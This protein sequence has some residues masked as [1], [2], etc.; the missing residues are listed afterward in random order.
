MSDYMDRIRHCA[1]GNSSFP[2]VSLSR[3]EAS[4]LFIRI[5]DLGESGQFR[6]ARLA[7]CIADFW[8]EEY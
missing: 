2:A 3:A 6:V 1:A 7:D 8:A 4:A 5:R